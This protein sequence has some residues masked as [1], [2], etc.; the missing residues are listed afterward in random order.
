MSATP[1]TPAAGPAF[2][3]VVLSPFLSYAK[4]DVITEP[5]AIAEVEKQ[6]G[7]HVVRVTAPS[8]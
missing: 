6:Y 5:A 4:G 3:Y 7:P 8:S 1:S 2:H